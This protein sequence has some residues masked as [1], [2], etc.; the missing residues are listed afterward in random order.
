MATPPYVNIDDTWGKGDPRL[1]LLKR[2]YPYIYNDKTDLLFYFL[3]NS[4]NIGRGETCLIVSRAFLEAYKADKLRMWLADHSDFRTVIDFRNHYVFVGVGITTAIVS[5]TQNEPVQI[6]SMHQLKD[7]S[8]ETNN[9]AGALEHPEV[10]GKI[11]V[12]QDRFGSAPW[13]FASA[14]VEQ[15]LAKIDAAGE[16]LGDV[17]Q[18]GQGMQ[19]GRNGVFGG[20]D[21]ATLEEWGVPEAQYFQ[22][23]RNSDIEQYW[24]RDSGEYVLYLEDVSDFDDLSP[25]TRSYLMAHRRELEER[26]AYQRGDC[27][28]WR[29]TWPL[30]K[31]EYHRGKLLCPYL[32]THN[33]FALDDKRQYLGLTDTTILYDR[34]QPE[35]LEYVMGLLNSTLLS[36]RFLYIGKLKSGGIREYFWN[37]VSK[38]PIR[39]VDF[40]DE[41]DVSQHDRVVLLVTRLRQLRSQMDTIRHGDQ[42]AES[43]RLLASTQQE[44]DSLV[45]ELYGLSALDVDVINAVLGVAGTERPEAL[46][47]VAG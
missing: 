18:V 45:Y 32:A 15:V 25:M 22:R 40:G 23:A 8:F 36:F 26:A 42:P 21:L 9:L 31:D 13:I 35:R 12:E 39:R 7:Q 30:H 4:L 2:L 16:G 46:A 17:L 1:A 6:A 29:F 10:F 43:Q 44:L 27:E 11:S 14:S 34:G 28:W 5:L 3:A 33:R 41:L 37:S 24:V 38:L 20:L 47:E 19:T